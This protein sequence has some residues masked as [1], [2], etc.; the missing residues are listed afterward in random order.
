MVIIISVDGKASKLFLLLG[1]MVIIISVDGKATQTMQF[2]LVVLD[3]SSLQ[4]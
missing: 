1:E 3:K 2:K 4:K